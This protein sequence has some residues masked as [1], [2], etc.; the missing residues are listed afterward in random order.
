MNRRQ[1]RGTW[2][3]KPI[4]I[5]VVFRAYAVFFGLAGLM[6]IMWGPAW[7]GRGLAGAPFG[8]TTLAR[9]FGV[10]FVSASCCAAALSTFRNALARQRSLFWFALG[11]V[12]IWM[13]ALGRLRWAWEPGL[14]DEVV[15]VIGGTAFALLCLWLTAE[16]EFPREPFG[17]TVAYSPQTSAPGE[18]LRSQ[19]EQKIRQAA[20]QEERNRLARDLHD[21]IKQKIFAFQ[22]APQTAH[23][24]VEG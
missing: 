8:Q 21:S 9:M 12:A 14:G 2:T 20:A 16:G 6:L 24:G 22:T 5:A 17:T 7:F 11:H 4:S 10:A 23:V 18:P 19:Y 13:A 15:P 3:A 1:K